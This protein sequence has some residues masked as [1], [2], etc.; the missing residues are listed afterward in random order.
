MQLQARIEKL[1]SKIERVE[2]K[3]E[4]VEQALEE[5]TKYLG[6]SDHV[7]FAMLPSKIACYI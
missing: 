7:S 6:T 5:G 1:E 4:R 2:A 3:Q